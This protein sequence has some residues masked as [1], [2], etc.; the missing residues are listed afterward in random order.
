MEILLVARICGKRY[1][2]KKNL[3]SYRVYV[4][5]LSM[6]LDLKY[7]GRVATTEDIK[8]IE[9]LM[10]D[11]PGDSRFLL[12][13]KFCKEVGWTQPNGRPRDMVARGYMLALHRAGYITLPAK[14]MDPPNPLAKRGKPPLVKVD[15][16]PLCLRLK[17]AAPLK[18]VQVRRTNKEALFNSLVEEHHYLGYTQPVGEHLKYM[19]YGRARPLA[20]L[21]FSSAPR[22]IGPRDAFIGWNADTRRRNISLICYNT[23]FLILPW[24]RVK[25]LASHILS[26][27]ARTLPDDWNRV[28]NHPVY[29]IETFVD[30]SR[31]SGTCY[32]AANWIYLGDTKGLGKDSR[33]KIPNRTL[34]AIYGYPLKKDFR[35]VLLKGKP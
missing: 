26:K 28:Y 1:P 20:C 29:Y 8:I 17:D 7:R 24:V 4:K 12:S 5:V 9:N 6:E 19:V 32:R 15:T 34:K 31:F 18:F 10:A 3:R 2:V 33:D 35:K 22:H 11:N 30:R 21:A 27:V 14:R 25:Y 16:T 23:R 13:F